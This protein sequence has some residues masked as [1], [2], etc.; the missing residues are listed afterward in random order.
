[1]VLHRVRPLTVSN[2]DIKSLVVD[3][4]GVQK[5]TEPTI[6]EFINNKNIFAN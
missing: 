3:Q 5:V 4:K 1:M 2:E 6:T